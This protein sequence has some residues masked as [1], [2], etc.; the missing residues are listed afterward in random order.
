[1]SM[2][3]R[4]DLPPPSKARMRALYRSASPDAV[5][6]IKEALRLYEVMLGDAEA[7]VTFMRQEPGGHPRPWEPFALEGDVV[8]FRVIEGGKGNK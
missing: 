8:P 7:G 3:L 1:M 5:A 2:R 6:V 4:L